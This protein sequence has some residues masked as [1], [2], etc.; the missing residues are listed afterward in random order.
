D[1]SGGKAADWKTLPIVLTTDNR[2]ENPSIG[3]VTFDNT[4]V[5]N[6]N[7]ETPIGTQFQDKA[8]LTDQSK[9]SLL[10]Q[11]NGKTTPFDL[12]AFIQ[13]KRAKL[14]KIN[15]MKPAT[16][17][18]AKL[19]APAA[20][21]SASAPQKGTNTFYTRNQFTFLQY[22]QK[23]KAITINVTARKVYPRET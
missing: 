8:T 11:S 3:G 19:H 15:S 16:V 4:I 17:D 5:I 21:A 14:E 6:D 13:E 18:L 10:V 9:G 23:G 12:A 7:G 22:A 1:F 20:D 2:V